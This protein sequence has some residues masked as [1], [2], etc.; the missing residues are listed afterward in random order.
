MKKRIP[1]EKN[2]T[3][4]GKCIKDFNLYISDNPGSALTEYEAL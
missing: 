4:I 3:D 2:K 1:V